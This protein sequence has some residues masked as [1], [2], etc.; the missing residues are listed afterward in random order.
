MPCPDLALNQSEHVILATNQS[1]TINVNNT[2]RTQ[3][4]EFGFELLLCDQYLYPLPC[5][6]SS[7]LIEALKKNREFTKN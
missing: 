4:F 5:N 3:T 7:V 2:T 1:H 6:H